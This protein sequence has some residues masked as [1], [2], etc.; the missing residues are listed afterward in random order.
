ML[1]SLLLVLNLMGTERPDSGEIW[2]G[3]S[4]NS[5]R[6]LKYDNCGG[7][8][9][10]W[11][12]GPCLDRNWIRQCLR[13]ERRHYV[14]QHIRG[15]W[16]IFLGRY[17]C[18]TGSVLDVRRYHSAKMEEGADAEKGG[19]MRDWI[20]QNSYARRAG[21]PKIIWNGF[22]YYT[23]YPQGP[24]CRKLK[25][26]PTDDSWSLGSPNPK[27]KR[28]GEGDTEY[29][30]KHSSRYQSSRQRLKV[31][32]VFLPE[33]P[34]SANSTLSAVSNIT[35]LRQASSTTQSNPTGFLG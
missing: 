33:V 29:C 12:G 10:W 8:S 24:T 18:R 20:I 9:R 22:D 26:P 28:D 27:T 11:F 32:P 23:V 16:H 6:L 35:T 31:L 19:H 5:H 30:G 15:W 2:S 1:L 25:D 7:Y 17:C 3:N 34:N 4:S 14:G 13:T 21:G